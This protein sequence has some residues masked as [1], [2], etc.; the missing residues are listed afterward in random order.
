M[1]LCIITVKISELKIYDN[2]NLN[3][4]LNS[5]WKENFLTI[6]EKKK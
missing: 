4:Y 2:L 1:E 5:L 6:C 3:L